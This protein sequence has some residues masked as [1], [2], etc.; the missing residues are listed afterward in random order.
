[1]FHVKH[2]YAAIA[3]AKIVPRETFQHVENMNSSQKIVSRETICPVMPVKM[4]L[5]CRSEQLFGEI[6]E[7]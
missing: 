2:R 6:Q 3:W 4:A 1:M 5:D 7:Y